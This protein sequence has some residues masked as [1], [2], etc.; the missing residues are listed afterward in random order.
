MLTHHEQL[1]WRVDVYNADVWPEAVSQFALTRR[2]A[3]LRPD[4][5][6]FMQT[7]R[8]LTL[9]DE[10]YDVYFDSLTEATYFLMRY[11]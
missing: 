1:G 6:E 4:V 2:E 7:T 9:V 8:C 10:P 11:A 5:L 3:G